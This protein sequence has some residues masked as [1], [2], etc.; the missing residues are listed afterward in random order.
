MHYFNASDGFFTDCLYSLFLFFRC[1]LDSE[2]RDAKV[3]IK[4]QTFKSFFRFDQKL[5]PFFADSTR[6]QGK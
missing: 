1:E 2:F 3:T 5:P 6:R 4:P